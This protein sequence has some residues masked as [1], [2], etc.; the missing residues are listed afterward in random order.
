MPGGAKI[1]RK[2]YTTRRGVHVKSHMVRDM[3]APGNW[4]SKHHESGIGKLTPGE[5]SSKGY[6]VS[7]GRITRRR[8]LKKVVRSVGP[9][10]AFR[11]LNA[12]A[13]YTKRTSP[14]KSKTFK[15]DRNWIKKTFMK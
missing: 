12:I 5:L 3:G 10:S 7:K 14:T 4:K 6:A 15:T 1:R 13:T 8:A 11:K 2:G 9:L